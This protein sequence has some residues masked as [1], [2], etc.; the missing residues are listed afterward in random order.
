[1]AILSS[2]GMLPGLARAHLGE[3]RA[4]KPQPGDVVFAR[5]ML[6]V[7]NG[8]YCIGMTEVG[9]QRFTAE[10]ESAW[11]VPCPRQ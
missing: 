10:I 11:E 4:G 8:Q 7:F 6:A 9:L 3:P 5:D 2:V 1:M